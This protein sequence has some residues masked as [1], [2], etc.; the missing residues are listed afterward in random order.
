MYI[1][2]HTNKRFTIFINIYLDISTRPSTNAIATQM[3]VVTLLNVMM[4]Y[5][6]LSATETTALTI[7][8]K[9]T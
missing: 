5:T 2:K 1:E 3:R 7:R 9:I 6:G 4:E 8:Y